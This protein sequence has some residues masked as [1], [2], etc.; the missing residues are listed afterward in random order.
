M[1]SSRYPERG[2]PCSRVQIGLQSFWCALCASLLSCGAL[3]AQAQAPGR[4]PAVDGTLV[5]VRAQSL[6]VQTAGGDTVTVHLPASVRIIEQVPTTLAAV[7]AGRFIGTTAVQEADGQ[8]HAREIHVFPDS[9]RGAGEGQHPLGTPN[10]TMTNGDVESVNDNVMQSAL[11][12]S[13][14]R[15]GLVLRVDYQKSGQSLILVSPGV[16]VTLMRAGSRTLLK[17]GAN[18]TVLAQRGAAGRLAADTVIVHAGGGLR[19]GSGD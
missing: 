13:D 14:T 19:A 18:V 16:S 9:M 1:R 2:G 15:P 8:L 6:Q 12:T 7:K 10:T 11:G 5:D 4:P 17:P 3:A